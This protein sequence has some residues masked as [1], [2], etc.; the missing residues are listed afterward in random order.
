MSKPDL[1][2]FTEQGRKDYEYGRQKEIQAMPFL[3]EWYSAKGWEV[4][5]RTGEKLIYDFELTR[6]HPKNEWS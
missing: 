5:D 1:S 3:K 2:G 6:N 4:S